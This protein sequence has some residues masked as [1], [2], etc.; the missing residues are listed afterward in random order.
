MEEAFSRFE[1]VPDEIN[2]IEVA[3]NAEEENTENEI[4]RK[5]F[6]ER[7]YR[8]AARAQEIIDNH[9]HTQSELQKT[10]LYTK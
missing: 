9:R 10:E 7:Y 6:E 5:L 1:I 8:A 3:E 2:E 4:E